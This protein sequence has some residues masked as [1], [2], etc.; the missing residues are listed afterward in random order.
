MPLDS[1]VFYQ[2]VRVSVNATVN[3]TSTGQRLISHD[4]TTYPVFWPHRLCFP[5]TRYY[6]TLFPLYQDF[7]LERTIWVR[8]QM[9]CFSSYCRWKNLVDKLKQWY[10]TFL[11]CG[12]LKKALSMWSIFTGCICE[13][14]IARSTKESLETRGVKVNQWRGRP[15]K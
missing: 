2:P 12:S 8:C 14:I 3:W 6:F 5:Q 13:Q 1:S 7:Q 15:K 9:I 10:P 11:S 4:A